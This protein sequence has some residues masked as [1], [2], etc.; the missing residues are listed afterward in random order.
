MMP[1]AVPGVSAPACRTTVASGASAAIDS[2]ASAAR[3]PATDG[4]PSTIRCCGSPASTSSPSTMPMVP[5]PAVARQR[6]A[7]APSLPVP[8]TSTRALAR[9]RWPSSLSWGRRPWLAVRVD[10]AVLS[11]ATG[12]TRGGIAMSL[13]LA[14]SVASACRCAAEDRPSFV[15]QET[16]STVI[17]A[18]AAI[19][20]IDCGLAGQCCDEGGAGVAV[21]G[22]EPFP[23]S[24]DSRS[25]A[26][27][28]D[29]IGEV[30]PPPGR[31]EGRAS[32]SPRR[33]LTSVRVRLHRSR[34]MMVR[35]RTK[36]RR[37]CGM[38]HER[39][40]MPRPIARRCFR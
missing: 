17:S 1:A 38:P 33:R 20:R 13:T 8:I 28:E 10:S 29:Q 25:L 39:G 35:V 24:E 34:W 6:S 4:P 11:R 23:D 12:S 21:P 32:P 5:I 19:A 30:D 36:S 22:P 31:P 14:L 9:R 40:A 15:Q 2:A 18:S 3:A 37:P 27:P 7:G 16:T 26:I